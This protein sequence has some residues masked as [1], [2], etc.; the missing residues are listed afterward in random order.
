MF[1]YKALIFRLSW[2]LSRSSPPPRWQPTTWTARSSSST[3]WRRGSS[4][5]SSTPRTCTSRQR[6]RYVRITVLPNISVDCYSVE[7]PGCL[8]GVRN[9]D[10]VFTKTSPKRSFCITE[11]ERFGLVFT[12]IGSLNS[13]T[14]F[15]I[16]IF[17]IPDL[18]FEKDL[19]VK[20]WV[21]VHTYAVIRS[22]ELVLNMAL[23]PS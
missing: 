13:G 4:D 3:C 20:C 9:I 14:G 19:F 2:S 1:F 6:R 5:T 17:S 10:P 12:K 18:T 21:P 23:A 22:C 7:D 15:R 8:S 11:N 16:G